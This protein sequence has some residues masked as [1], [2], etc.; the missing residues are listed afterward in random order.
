MLD[1]L[2]GSLLLLAGP[3]SIALSLYLVVN[4]VIVIIWLAV[5]W[6]AW[7]LNGMNAIGLLACIGY[8]GCVATGQ[9]SEVTLLM[10]AGTLLG[11][12]VSSIFQLIFD[13]SGDKTQQV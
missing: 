4:P 8:L 10:T 13:L 3:V 1:R 7:S 5:S 9:H 11:F 6:L 2:S 12:S